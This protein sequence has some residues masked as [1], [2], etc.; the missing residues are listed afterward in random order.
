M[1]KPGR[2]RPIGGGPA[3][4]TAAF[5]Q[6][7]VKAWRT[8]LACADKSVGAAGESAGATAVGGRMERMRMP[9]WVRSRHMFIPAVVVWGLAFFG[10]SDL[11]PQRPVPRIGTQVILSAALLV[12]LA[13]L[14]GWRKFL[15]ETLP[16]LVICNAAVFIADGVLRQYYG[17]ITGSFYFC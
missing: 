6:T 2:F 4:N 9:G 3:G 14:E 7:N 17:T 8:Q 16:F 10:M 15:R 5:G 13:W 1:G 12:Y 11:L